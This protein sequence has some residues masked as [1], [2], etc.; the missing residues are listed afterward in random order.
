ME[1]YCDI[2]RK[3]IKKKS[4][5]TLNTRQVSGYQWSRENVIIRKKQG[6]QLIVGLG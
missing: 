4:N 2:I 1:K 6:E 5:E 3:S